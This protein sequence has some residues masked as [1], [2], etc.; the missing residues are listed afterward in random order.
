MLTSDELRYA[1][2][3]AQREAGVCTRFCA[4]GGACGAFEY[5]IWHNGLG[6]SDSSE[7]RV[8]AKPVLKLPLDYLIECLVAWLVMTHNRRHFNLNT[9]LGTARPAP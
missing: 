8:Y 5:T 1:L 7:Q 4:V 6:S 2:A 9:A 3:E